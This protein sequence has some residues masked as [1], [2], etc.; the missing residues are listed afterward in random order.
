MATQYTPI[1][2]QDIEKQPL[3][4][5]DN[6]H[7]PQ[8]RWSSNNNNNNNDT[9]KK[10]S[11]FALITLGLL[12]VTFI[13]HFFGSSCSNTMFV[14]NEKQQEITHQDWLATPYNINDVLNMNTLVAGCTADTPLHLWEGQSVYQVPHN[15]NGL[16]VAEKTGKV[17]KYIRL[18]D[19]KINVVEN[20]ELSQTKITFDIKLSE[21]I[22]NGSVYIEEE[23]T[24]DDYKLSVIVNDDDDEKKRDSGCV[25]INALIE[26]PSSGELD[27]F[28]LNT[29]TNDINIKDE[30]EFKNSLLISNIAGDLTVNKKIKATSIKL[31]NVSGDIQGVFD[32]N[33]GQFITD[34]VSGNINVAFDHISPGSTIISK[35]VNGKTDIQ[36]VININ[37]KIKNRKIE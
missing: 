33:Q 29:I 11:K 19:G 18:M 35:S 2:N 20:K 30:F 23:E 7:Q 3:Q 32:L 21:E 10:R 13:G 6:V 28:E 26:I 37:I 14:S 5:E 16:H 22:Q 24:E 25:Q 4:N 17:I 9:C 8:C 15:I 12:G 36:V 27:N 34:M 31:K 1:L